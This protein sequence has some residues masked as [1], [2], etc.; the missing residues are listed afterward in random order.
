MNPVY[1]SFLLTLSQTYKRQMSCSG[2]PK[3]PNVRFL[4]HKFTYLRM[5]IS[6]I[7]EPSSFPYARMTSVFFSKT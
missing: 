7:G 2:Q 3:N 1:N 5:V 6:N 4:Q